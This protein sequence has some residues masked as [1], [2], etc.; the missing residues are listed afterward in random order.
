MTFL[1]AQAGPRSAAIMISDDIVG[2]PQSVS[3]SG[4]GL[5]TG[6][7]ATFSGISLAFGTQLV[8]TTSPPQSVALNNY[9]TMTLSI[10]RITVTGNFAETDNCVPSL[11]PGATCTINVT[12]TPS[13]TG[14]LSGALSTA[15]DA[16]G[17]PQAVSLSG[18]GST[19][20]PLLT[21][22]CFATCVGQTKD[23]DECPAGAPA[24]KPGSVSVYPCGPFTGRVSVD[25]SRTCHVSSLHRGEGYC[26]TQ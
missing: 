12:F 20:T 18:T 24:E 14:V 3:L 13:E 26:V 17:T 4:I 19:N 7:N 11:A 15:D 16:S 25:T 6:P 2:S 5:N 23:P 22:Y 21:G 10:A 8:G 9:G 1:P